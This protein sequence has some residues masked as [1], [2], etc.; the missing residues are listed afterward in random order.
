MRELTILSM[1]NNQ[2]ANLGSLAGHRRLVLLEAANNQIGDLSPLANITSLQVLTLGGNNVRSL[3]PGRQ[4][5][6]APRQ[7]RLRRRQ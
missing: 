3:P 7:H 5:G 2:V 1:E 6:L 4:P